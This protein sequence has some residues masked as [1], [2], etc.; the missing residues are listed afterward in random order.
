MRQAARAALVSAAAT[1]LSGKALDARP[2]GIP[3]WVRSNYRDC[4]VALSGGAAV[5]IGSLSAALVGPAELRRHSVTLIA[6]A[7]MAGGY[8]DL[9]APR[10]EQVGDKGWRGHLAAARSGRL[11]G[12]VVK[13]ALIGGAA[14]CTARSESGGWR[15]AVPRAALIAGTANLLNLFDLRPGRAGK[16]ALAVGATGLSGPT[17]AIA[18]SVVGSAAAVLPEDLAERRML[19][20][21]GANTLGVLLGQRLAHGGP[22]LRWGALVTVG[23]LTMAS[24]R[25]SFSQVIAR[26]PWLRTMDEWGRSVP[27]DRD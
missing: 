5:V 17:G 14:L 3:G 19:G 2:I 7:A 20:D 8:D 11:S 22:A 10:H 15:R 25:V 26:T 27:T 1:F 18:A 13:V 16:V 24:E 6:A 21:L 9:L 23:G 12:G 4:P